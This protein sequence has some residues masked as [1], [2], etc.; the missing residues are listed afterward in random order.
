[1][2]GIGSDPV[3]CDLFIWAIANSNIGVTPSIDTQ[4]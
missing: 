4:A 1:M 3:V 2:I